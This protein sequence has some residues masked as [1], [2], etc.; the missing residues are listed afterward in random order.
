MEMS[1]LSAAR[2]RFDFP[3]QGALRKAGAL[4]FGLS[5]LLPACLAAVPN[6]AQAQ[7]KRAAEATPRAKSG[8]EWG[9]TVGGLCA[10]V[11]AVAPDTDEQKPDFAAAKRASKYDHTDD[12]TLLVELKNVSDQPISLQG[13]RYGDTVTPPWPGK[14]VSE[15]FAPYLFDCEYFDRQGKPIEVPSHK[16]VEGDLMMSLTGGSAETVEPGKSLV[17]LIRPTKWDHC[18]ERLLTAGDF[19]IRVRYHGP[20]RAVIQEIAQ[21]WPDQP[22]TRVWSEGIVAAQG[23]FRIAG[24]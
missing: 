10:R 22:L 13:T 9:E 14:S 3:R 12:V 16:M 17:M 24:D 18:L 11:I 2:H 5:L 7:V 23:T 20:T 8:T 4:C 15:T 19:Q 6:A 21:H 1:D